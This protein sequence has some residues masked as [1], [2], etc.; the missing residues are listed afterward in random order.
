MAADGTIK[1]YTD[2]DTSGIRVGTKDV[3]GSMSK[4]GELVKKIG[5]STSDTFKKSANEAGKAAEHV[6][7]ESDEKIQ[8]ILNDA[9]KSMKSKAASIAAIYRKQGLTQEEAFKKAWQHIERDSAS[10]AKKVKKHIGGIGKKSKQVGNEMSVSLTSGV[11]GAVKKIGGMIA[12]AFA[13]QKIAQ[14]G[15]ECLDL[16]SDLAEVQNVVDVTFPNMTDQVDQFAKSAA[17]SFGLSE[18]MAKQFTGTFG[19]MAKSFGFSEKSAYD[20]STALTG[21]AGDVASFYN[22]SQGEAYTKIKS[23]FTGETE[24]LKDLGVVMTQ[25]AL[26]SYA[27]ANGYGKTTSA[28]TEQEKVALRY[29]FVMDQLSAARGDFART[30]DSWANQTR[31]LNL[32]L[33]SIK[34]TIGQG[35]INVFTPVI[36]VINILLSKLATVAEAFKSFTELITGNKAQAGSTGTLQEALPTGDE[37]NS[38]ADGAENLAKSTDKAAKATKEAAK[39][40]NGYLSPLDE[41]ERYQEDN[42]SPGS[43]PGSGSGGIGAVAGSVDYGKLAEGETVIDKAN[44]ALDSLIKKLNRLKKLF[45]KGFWDGLGDYKPILEQMQ[46]DISSIGNSMKDIFQSPEVTGAASKLADTVAYSLGQIVGSAAGIGF[47]IASN[48]I[49]GIAEYLEGSKDFIKSRIVSLLDSTAEIYTIAGN[50]SAAVAEVFSVITGENGR[51]ITASLIG[52]FSDGFLGIM[53]LAMQF[54]ADIVNTLAAPFVNNA[55]TIRTAIDTGI[56]APIATLLE[57]LHTSLLE[58]F[59]TVQAVYDEHIAPLFQSIR[60]GLDSI[61]GKILEAWNTYIAPVLNSL[62]ERA[63]QVWAEHVQPVLNKAVELLGKVADLLK[64]LWENVVQPFIEWLIENILPV[65]GPI[66]EEVGGFVIELGGTVADSFGGILDILGGFLDYLTGIF[67][68]DNELAWKGIQ[69]IIGGFRTFVGSIFNFIQTH[70]LEP[71][72]SFLNTVFEKDWSESFGAMGEVM[73]WFFD[74]VELVWN[75]IKDLLNGIIGFIEDVFTGDWESAWNTITGIFKGVFDGLMDLVKEPLNTVIDIVNGAISKINGAIGGIESAISF[76]PWE[77]PT[78]FGSKTIGFSANFP[79]VPH[80]PYLATGAVIPPN[81][82]FAAVLGDQKHG[83]NIEAPEELIRKI[84][85]EESGSNREGNAQYRFTAQI[86]RRTLFEEMLS[87]AELVRSQ[88][89]RNPFDM[90]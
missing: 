57:T 26:D 27:L 79:R 60:D 40:A 75:D 87:E 32:Q 76:G 48:L 23:V 10:G 71:F 24:S 29:R 62:A 88:T 43:S 2:V 4:I 16:G 68:G 56:L 7:T 59:Q 73:N 51:S 3:E 86:N 17:Q 37:Y 15:K 6:A 83:N 25:T 8:S 44:S 38:A 80:I 58:T 46:E 31:I 49:G 65:V 90:A 67:T 78:P 33:N 54:G 41:I 82:P 72:D 39:A 20:M 84:V 70:I 14:F 47:S 42:D 66:L 69:E 5:K 61:A 34:A 55:E 63:S 11:T 30:S 13:V 81:A 77:V 74:G 21:L 19:A 85:R 45:T 28:M 89:G 18:T 22:L 9:E 64:A 52:I 35:L 1:I 53:S 36:K 12:A 50:L